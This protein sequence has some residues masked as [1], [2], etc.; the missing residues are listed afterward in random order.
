M[1]PTVSRSVPA[2]REAI[3]AALG[4]RLG[5]LFVPNPAIAKYAFVLRWP[6]K[7]VVLSGALRRA[8]QKVDPNAGKVLVVG[9]DFTAEATQVAANAGC[10]LLREGEHGWTDA[11]YQHIRKIAG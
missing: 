2:T 4:P 5:K 1:K 9:R 11:S 8:L 3:E 6:D 7:T 10:D